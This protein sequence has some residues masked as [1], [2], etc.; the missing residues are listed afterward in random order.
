MILARLRRRHAE[1]RARWEAL[2]RR[3]G[4]CCYEKDV[5]GLTV[6]TNWAR[7]CIHLDTATRLCTV[8]DR[9]F[10]ACP[11]CRGMTVWHALFVRWL[12]P[13]CG[14]VRRYRPGLSG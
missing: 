4:Q 7:P 2:C 14:Y 12:P 13:T 6:V 1:R 8:Y 5:R 11:Q 9:R 3:C 10:Q